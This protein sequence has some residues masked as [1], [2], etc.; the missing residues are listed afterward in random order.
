MKKLLSLV[1]FRKSRLEIAPAEHLK[2]LKT[3]AILLSAM[4][5]LFRNAGYNEIAKKIM[6]AKVL[7][8]SV[9]SDIIDSIK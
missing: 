1:G 4:E 9:E 2:T 3:I 8:I 5:R 7:L 6:Q